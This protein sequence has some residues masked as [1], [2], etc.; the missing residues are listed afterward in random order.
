[1]PERG[2]LQGPTGRYAVCLVILPGHRVNTANTNAAVV[3]RSMTVNP[4][5]T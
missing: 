2:R 4:I 1:M 3:D 5:L